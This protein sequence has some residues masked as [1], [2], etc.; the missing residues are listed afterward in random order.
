[1][2]LCLGFTLD[3]IQEQYETAG[4]KLKSATGKTAEPSLGH[5]EKFFNQRLLK[6]IQCPQ[7]KIPLLYKVVNL[8]LFGI[9]YVSVQVTDGKADKLLQ[10]G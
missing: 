6:E 9:K 7:H 5:S 3:K 10:T 4:T 1:M 8:D 2:A